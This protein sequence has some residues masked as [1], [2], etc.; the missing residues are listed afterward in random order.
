M[1]LN[2]QTGGGGTQWVSVVPRRGRESSVSTTGSLAII[3]ETPRPSG[4]PAPETP[5]GETVEPIHCQ[6][7]S[8]TEIQI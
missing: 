8:R 3:L 7:L 1:F 2:H 6:S 4:P 5:A